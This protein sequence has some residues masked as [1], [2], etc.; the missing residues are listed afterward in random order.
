LDG[1]SVGGALLFAAGRVEEMLA[2]LG[3]SEEPLVDAVTALDEHSEEDEKT[4]APPRRYIP[5]QAEPPALLAVAEKVLPPNVP[6]HDLCRC[7]RFPLP[8][9][10][11]SWATHSM[12]TAFE[13]PA[14]EWV[15]SP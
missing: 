6:W 15:A 14:W 12:H 13:L 11:P 10:Y 1:E 8:T 3:L 5:D 4:E 9:L 2:R 7:W